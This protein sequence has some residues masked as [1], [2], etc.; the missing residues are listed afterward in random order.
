MSV[1]NKEFFRFWT[2]GAQIAV[3]LASPITEPGRHPLLF[4][5]LNEF[6][7]RP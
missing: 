4:I 6:V 3:R 7:Q 1:A 2:G 5:Y